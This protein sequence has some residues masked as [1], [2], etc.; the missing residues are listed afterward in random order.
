MSE[1]SDLQKELRRVQCRGVVTLPKDWR[2]NNA[3]RGD[4][5]LVSS[6]RFRE[7]VSP[8]KLVE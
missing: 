4:Y 7:V 5:V 2:E 1:A 6:P 3:G 8:L